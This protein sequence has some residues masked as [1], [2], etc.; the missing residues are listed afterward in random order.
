M[1]LRKSDAGGKSNERLVKYAIG[2]LAIGT[3]GYKFYS[4]YQSQLTRN[5]PKYLERKEVV[6]IDEL[7]SDVKIT[8]KIVNQNDKSELDLI[9]FQY[10]TCPFCC[11]VRAYL[12]AAGFTYSVVEVNAVLRQSIKWSKYKKVPML[13]ARNKDGKYVQLTESSMIISA[14][15]SYKLDPTID[16]LDLA[17]FY[18]NVVYENDE[19]KKQQDIL[20]KY[21]VMHKDKV[22]VNR[23]KEDLT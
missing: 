23:T 11:K 6:V 16:L 9:L 13:L 18:P 3:V 12:D 22:P 8:R 21:F 17:G 5:S 4:D 19:G 7:P 10:Q 14:L 15:S 2:G 20:N 1:G